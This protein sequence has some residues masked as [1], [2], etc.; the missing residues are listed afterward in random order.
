MTTAHDGKTAWGYDVLAARKENGD[1]DR[2]DAE[3]W[4]GD[5][6]LDQWIEDWDDDDFWDALFDD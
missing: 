4:S 1:Y 2:D 6:E 5:D 3:D